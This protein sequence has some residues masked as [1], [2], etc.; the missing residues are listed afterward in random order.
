MAELYSHQSIQFTHR[1]IDFHDSVSLIPKYPS[2]V[3]QLVRL[4]YEK[5]K[6]LLNYEYM[7]ITVEPFVYLSTLALHKYS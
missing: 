1:P 5:L 4:A 6:K 2:L 7:A 3:T